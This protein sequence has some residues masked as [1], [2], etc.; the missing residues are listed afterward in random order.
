[1]VPPRRDPSSSLDAIDVLNSSVDTLKARDTPGHNIGPEDSDANSTFLGMPAIDV[2]KWTWP[3][4][5]TFGRGNG[6]KRGSDQP[7]IPTPE[8][9]KP[10]PVAEE[11]LSHVE[12]EINE[13]ALEDAISSDSLSI[14]RQLIHTEG[15]GEDQHQNPDRGD[16]PVGPQDFLSSLLSTTVSASKIDGI[17]LLQPLLPPLP[18]FSMTR[19]H[20]APLRSPISTTPVTIHYFI[21]SMPTYFSTL[22]LTKPK[23]NQA[24]LALLKNE[25][26]AAENYDVEVDDLQAAA[27]GILRLFDEVDSRIYE[28]GL[29]GCVFF[30]TSDPR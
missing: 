14:S 7:A 11:G 18:E 8:K 27:G 22:L 9:E 30:L 6:S 13:S 1:M 10:E 21:V 15:Q 28:A 16:L 4:Y 2:R 25:G 12:V 19:V 20:L 17:P 5:L 24:M 23:R 26:N 29:E 3:G